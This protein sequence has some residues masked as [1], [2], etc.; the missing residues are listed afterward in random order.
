[1]EPEP[2]PEAQIVDELEQTE[3]VPPAEEMDLPTFLRSCADGR[4]HSINW[5]PEAFGNAVRAGFTSLWAAVRDG[6]A[7]AEGVRR[8]RDGGYRQLLL[9]LSR[10]DRVVARAQRVAGGALVFQAVG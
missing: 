2:E 6:S 3:G 4:S 5:Q 9:P 1:M 10:A 8:R 7:L